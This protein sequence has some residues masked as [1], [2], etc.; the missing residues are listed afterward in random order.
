[1]KEFFV[2]FS[3]ADSEYFT[4]LRLVAGAVCSAHEIDLDELEDF[5]VCVT[6][7]A[8]MLKSCGYEK[9]CVGFGGG[10]RV[11][12]RVYGEGG[13]PAAGDTEL[14]RALVSAL[15]KDCDILVRD[16]IVEEIE[17]GL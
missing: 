9:V 1:M 3:L 10:E 4:A 12:C 8:L 14:S 5:K 7:S 11:S 15:I 6:E 2:K 17:L 16:G 13:T